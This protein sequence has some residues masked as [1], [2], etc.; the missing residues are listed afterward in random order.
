MARN[1][2]IARKILKIAKELTGGDSDQ[3]C[4]LHK[5][6]LIVWSS[7]DKIDET[8]KDLR[9]IDGK[10]ELDD[11]FDWKKIRRINGEKVS[12]WT[13][14][15]IFGMAKDAIDMLKKLGYKEGKP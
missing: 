13:W 3:G 9:R 14:Y 15:G 2:E 11:T 4:Y 10:L 5:N 6:G 8:H 7:P 1:E 12:V